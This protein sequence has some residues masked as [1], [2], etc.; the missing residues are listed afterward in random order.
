MIIPDTSLVLS[1]EDNQHC[2]SYQQMY[3]CLELSSWFYLPSCISPDKKEMIWWCSWP[4]VREENYLSY[5]VQSEERN[6]NVLMT[7]SFMQLL[8][9]KWTVSEIRK[10]KSFLQKLKSNPFAATQTVC[11]GHLEISSPPSVDSSHHSEQSLQTHARLHIC[12]SGILSLSQ[13]HPE[14]HKVA[15]AKKRMQ[16]KKYLKLQ[17]LHHAHC[18][19]TTIITIWLITWHRKDVHLTEYKIPSS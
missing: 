5:L 10:Q 4:E 2:S 6:T 18:I 9:S 7:T 15:S 8:A 17:C 19:W 11:G 13:P 1:W 3:L 12:H 16:S 14:K